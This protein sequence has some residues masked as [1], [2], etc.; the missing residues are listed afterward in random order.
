MGLEILM[1]RSGFEASETTTTTKSGIISRTSAFV[2]DSAICYNRY[3]I[4]AA[5]HWTEHSPMR[6]LKTT[7]KHQ[8]LFI[9]VPSEAVSRDAIQ[10]QMAG[11]EMNWKDS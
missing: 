11:R 10:R 6:T 7:R 2:H 4:K 1:C 8:S 5:L 3:S 9:C